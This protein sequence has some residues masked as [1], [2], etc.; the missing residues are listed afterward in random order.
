MLRGLYRF[1]LYTVSSP[2]SFSLP[3]ALKDCYKLA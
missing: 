3:P 1:Y 2:C